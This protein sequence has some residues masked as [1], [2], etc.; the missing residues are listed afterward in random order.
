LSYSNWFDNENTCRL[1]QTETKNVDEKVL[2]VHYF[3]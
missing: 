2:A 3:I 1:T